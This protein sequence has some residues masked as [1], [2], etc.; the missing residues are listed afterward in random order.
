MAA[1]GGSIFGGV[2]LAAWLGAAHAA[3]APRL[4]A[5]EIRQ[6]QGGAGT[7]ACA[8][9]ALF[10]CLAAR[11]PDS[12]LRPDAVPAVER[13]VSAPTPSEYRIE[14]ESV[15]RPEDVTGVAAELE[16][17]RPGRTLVEAQRR[18][19]PAGECADEA[20]DDYQIVLE[21]RGERWEIVHW[22]EL[23]DP[24][25]PAELPEGLRRPPPS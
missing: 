5:G 21:R 6:C 12:C 18:V 4:L 2:V 22:T 15:I 1:S 17:Y 19:C 7:V 14:R 20:W 11:P 16:W 25:T 24:D 23:A 8:V 9:E 10:V 3:D 13:V